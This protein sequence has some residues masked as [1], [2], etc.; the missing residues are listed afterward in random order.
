MKSFYHDKA[1]LSIAL[2]HFV[3][4]SPVITAIKIQQKVKNGILSS[5]SM[6][7]NNFI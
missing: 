7:I 3:N 2:Q 5:F 1:I 6:I 4:S